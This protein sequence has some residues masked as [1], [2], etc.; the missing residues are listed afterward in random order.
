VLDIVCVTYFLT[1]T[2]MPDPQTSDMRRSDTVNDVS[3]RSLASARLS[4]L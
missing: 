2:T 4:K 3:A 1:S